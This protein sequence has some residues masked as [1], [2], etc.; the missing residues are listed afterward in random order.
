LRIPS[1]AIEAGEQH[2]STAIRELREETGVRVDPDE[3]HL[4]M[5]IRSLYGH[6][7]IYEALL[8]HEPD[9]KVDNREITY[10]GF[11]PPHEVTESNPAVRNYLVSEPL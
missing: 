4:V 11:H 3:L 2:A 9:L 10:A 5:T 7:Y 6:R 8:D 1:G